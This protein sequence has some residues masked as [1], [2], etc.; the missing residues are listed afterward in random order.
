[1]RILNTPDY[2]FERIRD[3][4]GKIDVL[5]GIS[6]F[7]N[8]ETIANVAR[9]AAQGIVDYFDSRGLIVNSDGGSKD[10]TAEKFVKSDTLEIPKV[11]FEYIGVPGKGSA[12]RSI[13]EVAAFLKPKVV[14]FLDADLRSVE[15]WWVERLASPVIDGKADYVPPYY[16]RHKYDGTITNQVC[17]PMTSILYGKKVRQPIGGDFGVGL[18]MI[19]LFLNKPDKTWKKDV[20]RF[21]IDIWM[22]TNAIAHGGKLVQAALGAKV[23]DV[24]DPGKHLGP[25]FKQVVGTLFDMME[26]FKETW[27]DVNSMEDVDVYG[28]IPKVELE[29]LVVDVENMRK[30]ASEIVLN[31]REKFHYLPEDLVDIVMNEG[32]IDLEGWVRILY[33][34]S[35]EYRKRKE[36]KEDVIEN[37]LPFYFARVADFVMKTERMSNEEAERIIIDQLDV[38]MDMKGY[39]KKRWYD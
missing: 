12:M 25:M 34:S 31:E 7:N 5:V 28:K 20:A 10:G 23:H 24:K 33:D 26:E 38:F 16:T 22:T 1:M 4:V 19:E 30:K 36:K 14:I 29:D 18:R 37:L 11:S 17:F 32:K 8:S 6:S 21:G 27:F 39:L 2:V 3:Y 35:A 9:K 15:P 13:M